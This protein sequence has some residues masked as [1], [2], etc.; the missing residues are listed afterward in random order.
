M[1]G[2]VRCATCM[3]VGPMWVVVTVWGEM[4]D[5]ESRAK[6]GYLAC[7]TTREVYMS[8]TPFVNRESQRVAMVSAGPA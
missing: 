4:C 3:Q 2:A 1:C 7:C 6:F 8:S 5:E